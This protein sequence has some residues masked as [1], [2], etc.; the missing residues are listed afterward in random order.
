MPKPELI[1]LLDIAIAL[2]EDLNRQLTAIDAIL[3]AKHQAADAR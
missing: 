1:K 3:V 2:G